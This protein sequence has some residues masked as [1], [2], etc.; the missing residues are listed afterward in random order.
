MT[1]LVNL[2]LLLILSAFTAA[3]AQNGSKVTGKIEDGA[4]KGLESSTVSLLRAADS[5]V[6]KINAA[7]KDGQFR[8]DILQD[9]RYLVLATAVGYQA[10]YS[11]SFKV[12]PSASAITLKSMQLK[13]AT[14]DL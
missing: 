5:T 1:K 6:V 13:P 7:D 10:G 3:Q 4:G 11:D 9:G 14:K 12:S 2:L 8:Y